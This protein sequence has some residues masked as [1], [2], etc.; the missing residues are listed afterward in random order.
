MKAEY[1]N[2][3]LSTITAVLK[4]LVP[5]IQVE[6]GNLQLKEPP[7]IVSGCA[8]LIGVAGTAEGR[9]ILDMTKEVAVAIASASNPEKFTEF[10]SF[11]A[12][13]INEITNMI[14]GGAIT[15]LNSQGFKMDISTPSLFVGEDL[16]LFD[17]S[18][19]K[20]SIVI[21]IKTN[22]GDIIVNVALSERT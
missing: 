20:E 3:F 22:Y 21:P 2:P 13:T 12:S 17:T 4:E 14:C 16:E 5:D 9:V 15:Q 7:I 8:S 6:R 1:I 11:V 18:S 10:N 19:V